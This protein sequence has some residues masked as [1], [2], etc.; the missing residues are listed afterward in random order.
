M[1]DTSDSKSDAQG[2]LVGSI[3]TAVN[4]LIYIL[5]SLLGDLV[6]L[7][8]TIDLHSIILGSSPSFST[9]N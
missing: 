1:V 9:M 6:K 8:I 7:A 3:P 4:S 5:H 2:E